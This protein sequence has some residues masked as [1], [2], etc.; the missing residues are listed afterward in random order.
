MEIRVVGW[1][2]MTLSSCRE[3]EEVLERV[4]MLERSQ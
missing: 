3:W 4:K 1:I 2:G